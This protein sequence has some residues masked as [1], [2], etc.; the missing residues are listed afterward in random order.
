MRRAYWR[1]KYDRNATAKLYELREAGFAIH[2]AIKA[3][4]FLGQFTD[5]FIVDG[6]GARS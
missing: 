5:A 2:D 1:L 6:Y 3:L 4:K